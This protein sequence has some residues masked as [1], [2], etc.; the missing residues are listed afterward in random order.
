MTDSPEMDDV[1]GEFVKVLRCDSGYA[2]RYCSVK[3]KESNYVLLV[4]LYFNADCG[5]ISQA[6]QMFNILE[7]FSI[8]FL[9]CRAVGPTSAVILGDRSASVL[10]IGLFLTTEDIEFPSSYISSRLGNPSSG[11]WKCDMNIW[12]LRCLVNLGPSPPASKAMKRNRFGAFCTDVL[13]NIRFVRMSSRAW[14]W[15]C[16]GAS[17]RFFAMIMLAIVLLSG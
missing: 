1:L 17:S 2:A 10:S 14:I 3:T 15:T 4:L 16:L 7:G 11:S 12:S 9:A 5:V 8:G 13:V 6:R